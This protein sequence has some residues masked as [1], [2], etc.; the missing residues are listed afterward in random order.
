MFDGNEK[1]WSLMGEEFDGIW[2]LKMTG[3]TEGTPAS[4]SFNHELVMRAEDNG[5]PFVGWLH[6]H[7]YWTAVPSDRDV[8][9]MGAWCL[10]LGRPLLCAITGSDGLRGWWFLDDETPPV[11]KKLVQIPFG[12]ILGGKL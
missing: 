4:V 3:E 1:C 11:E 5:T 2:V 10:S 6:S 12:I 8:K 7:P 9:T